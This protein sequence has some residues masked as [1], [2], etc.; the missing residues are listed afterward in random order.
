MHF[1]LV[2]SNSFMSNLYSQRGYTAGEFQALQLIVL[3]VFSAFAWTL[4]FCM[5]VHFLEIGLIYSW[6]VSLG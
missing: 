6:F 4:A 5:L 1:H 3:V 2:S